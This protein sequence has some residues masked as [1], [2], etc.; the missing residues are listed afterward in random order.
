MDDECCVRVSG[1]LEPARVPVGLGLPREQY[2]QDSQYNNF[3]HPA[4]ALPD[5]LRQTR[6]AIPMR[7]LS[8][9][10]MGRLE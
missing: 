2:P 7:T 4:F 6:E 8:N 1:H 3:L 10:A 9:L 5:N